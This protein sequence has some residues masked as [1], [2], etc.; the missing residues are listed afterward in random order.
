MSKKEIVLSRCFSCHKTYVFELLK[1]IILV[2]P[3]E[4]GVTRVKRFL[5]PSCFERLNQFKFVQESELEK[6][7]EV[8]NEKE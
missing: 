3:M 2:E 5:C 6:K 1:P 4:D 8:K 7:K